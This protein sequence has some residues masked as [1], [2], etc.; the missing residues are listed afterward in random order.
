MGARARTKYSVLRTGADLLDRNFDAIKAALDALGAFSGIEA[1]YAGTDSD[2]ALTGR[3]LRLMDTTASASTAGLTW[4]YDRTASDDEEDTISATITALGGGAPVGGSGTATRFAFWDGSGVVTTLG[5][6]DDAYW[7]KSGTPQF[8]RFTA[9]EGASIDGGTVGVIPLVLRAKTDS[10]PAAGFGTCILFQAEDSGGTMDHLGR[11]DMLW[12][13]ATAGSED[14]DLV[15]RLRAAGAAYAEV[16]RFTGT[17]FLGVGLTAPVTALHVAGTTFA[18][19]A[20]TAR[21][22]SSIGDGGYLVLGRSRGTVTSPTGLSVSDVIGTL[23][24]DGYTDGWKQ[25]ASIRAVAATGWGASGNDSPG[26]M[27]FAITPDGSATP[28]DCMALTSGNLLVR[29]VANSGS[30]TEMLTIE[31]M[32]ADSTA[33]VGQFGSYISFRAEGFTNGSS[34]E[35]ARI[36]AVWE[37]TQTNDTTTRD[38][39]LSFSTMLDNTMSVQWC[40]DS[41]GSLKSRGADQTLWLYADAS[42]ATVSGSG[43]CKVRNNGGVMEGSENGGTYI[44]VLSKAHVAWGSG[45]QTTAQFLC[46][47]APGAGTT[48]AAEGVI[49][50]ISASRGGRVVYA[51]AHVT[52]APG[53]V[54]TTTI[55][56]RK[57]GAD[58]GAVVTITGAA[59]TGTWSGTPVDVAQ[60]DVLTARIDFTGAN[61]ADTSFDTAY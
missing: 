2:V 23:S 11:L 14:S 30:A 24:F 51:K 52:T 44:P 48:S 10:T 58:T 47:F 50:K 53:G 8:A 5:S 9:D 12:S 40:I 3:R 42:A 41:G 61:P 29:D 57:N 31:R 1:I 16:A 20:L 43:E 54:A 15:I 35:Q 21:L 59:V 27:Y 25:A 18:K 36:K 38:S 17:G 13:D 60:G 34:V 46:A 19:S 39:E 55:T 7:D 32:R 33:P 37:V 6:D 45:T 22:H 49:N 28:V 4:S 26:A 56:L